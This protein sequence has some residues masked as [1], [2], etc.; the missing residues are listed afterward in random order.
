MYVRV[1]ENC[2]KFL[3]ENSEPPVPSSKWQEIITTVMVPDVSADAT[4][5]SLSPATV[6]STLVVSSNVPVVPAQFT[7]KVIAVPFLLNLTVL[8]PTEEF[9]CTSTSNFLKLPAF[10]TTICEVDS[11][12]LNCNMPDSGANLAEAAVVA[13]PADSEETIKAVLANLYSWVVDFLL[14]S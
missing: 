4:Q 6:V 14:Y 7:P 1:A 2:I 11:G 9:A 10:R 12:V 13:T 3:E 8:V 5:V